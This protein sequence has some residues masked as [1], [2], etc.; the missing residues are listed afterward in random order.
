MKWANSNVMI[1]SAVLV[2]AS[3]LSS[4]YRQSAG[5]NLIGMSRSKVSTFDHVVIP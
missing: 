1:F 3:I 4:R 5:G 2:A